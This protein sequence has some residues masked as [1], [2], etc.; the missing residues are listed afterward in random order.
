[1]TP[2]D[3]DVARVVHARLEAQ[4]FVAAAALLAFAL[5]T[6]YAEYREAVCRAIAR[7]VRAAAAREARTHDL[8]VQLRRRGLT[9]GTRRAFAELTALAELVEAFAAGDIE[10]TRA[11]LASMG[12]RNDRGARA[13]EGMSR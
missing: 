2:S 5:T 12:E 10:A 8:L 11:A 6:P 9:R 7:E 4:G 13:P 3:V 1:M